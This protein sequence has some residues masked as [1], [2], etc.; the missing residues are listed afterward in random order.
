MTGTHN[1]QRVYLVRHGET[2]WSLSGRH[3][4]STDVALTERGRSAA[5]R[6]API[7]QRQS[8]DLV[9]VSPLL[10]AQ[11]TCT[12]AGFAESAQTDADLCEWNYGLYEGKTP[13]EIRALAPDWLLFR[14][15]C[16]EGEDTEQVGSRVDRVIARVRASSGNAA[17]FAHGHILRVLGAR[18]LGLPVADGSRFR[19]DT[20]TL[21]V[22]SYYHGIPAIE[23][24]N[25]SLDS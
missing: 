24:W 22:L 3:T 14:D 12:L 6:L 23:R 17:L 19:L 20:S 21:S 25:D 16:P 4:G 7:L 5:E 1:K 8:F 11:E 13:Q 10:R 9:L 2:A 15:G 18:W